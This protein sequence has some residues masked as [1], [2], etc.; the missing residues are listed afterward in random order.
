MI[1][2]IATV[3]LALVL[4]SPCLA[5]NIPES[6]VRIS[7]ES[8]RFIDQ[9]SGTLVSSTRVLTASHVVASGGRVTVTF[10]SGKQYYATRVK[11]DPR[12]DLALL[13]IS[14][15]S[16]KPYSLAEAAPIIGQ[17]LFTAGYGGTG[18]PLRA[19]NGRLLEYTTV[20][21]GS[22]GGVILVSGTVRGG[23][24][25]GPIINENGRLVGVVAWTD[26]AGAYGTHCVGIREFLGRGRS[27]SRCGPNGCDVPETPIIDPIVFPL[28]DAPEVPDAPVDDDRFVAIDIRLD[29]L[30][31]AIR[32]IPGGA[33]G[34][35]GIQG[36]QGIPGDDG[37]DGADAVV[38]LDELVD[39]IMERLPG[40]TVQATKDDGTLVGEPFVMRLGETVDLARALPG[41]RVQAAEADGTLSGDIK[42]IHLG[43]RLLLKH[44]LTELPK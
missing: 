6:I 20:G 36:E 19:T 28:P 40:I 21:R 12:P 29:A 7:C 22:P 26:S 38:V 15:V 23:D 27:Q 13:A 44:K 37:K 10:Q 14:E 32:E 34:D 1:R 5:G 31:I 4:S 43:E 11:Q 18:Q 9:G 2:L 42:V 3:L 25:G 35:P 41:I 16:V 33:K 8:G 39:K 17:K 30:M 24:S